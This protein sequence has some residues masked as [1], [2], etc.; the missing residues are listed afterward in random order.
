MSGVPSID[1]R[2]ALALERTLLAWTRT[3]IALMG[4][5]VVLARLG[6][7]LGDLAPGVPQ[8]EVAGAAAVGVALVLLGGVVQAVGVVSHRRAVA[9]L[10][11]HAELPL[12]YT[13]P[14]TMFGVLLVALALALAVYLAVVS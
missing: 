14:A 13:T 6:M 8:R 1:P 2:V 3:A 5:G 9:R 11:K 4:F 12:E 7:W 10:R